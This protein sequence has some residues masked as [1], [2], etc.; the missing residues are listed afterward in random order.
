MSMHLMLSFK[1]VYLRSDV[2]EVF[3]KPDLCGFFCRCTQKELHIKKMVAST[4][5][6][7][8]TACFAALPFLSRYSS[9]F[10][11]SFKAWCNVSQQVTS[12]TTLPSSIFN[13]RNMQCSLRLNVCVCAVCGQ[14]DLILI[15]AQHT[16]TEQYAHTA[17]DIDI[18][19][20]YIS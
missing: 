6:P 3:S 17:C 10:V 13:E 7:T 15:K 19:T 9:L 8:S 2:G 4:L 20:H 11:R 12:Q 5:W 1:V 18:C 14:M 16:C